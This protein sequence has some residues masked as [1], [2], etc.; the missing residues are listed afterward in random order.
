MEQAMEAMRQNLDA[1]SKVLR[2]N[3]TIEED[4]ATALRRKESTLP[5]SKPAERSPSQAA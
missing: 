4:V 3:P 5:I 1:V 2:L